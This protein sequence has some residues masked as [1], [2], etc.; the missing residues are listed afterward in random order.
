MAMDVMRLDDAEREWVRDHLDVADAER[1]QDPFDAFRLLRDEH[2]LARSDAHLDGFWV[3]SRHAD[4]RRIALDHRGFLSSQGMAIP[5]LGNE[6]PLIPIEI[7][8]P[9]HREYRLLIN[10]LF[11][12]QAVARSE[13]HVRAE[14]RALVRRILDAHDGRCDL[15]RALAYEQPMIVLWSEPFLGAPLP[16]DG[17]R[18]SALT[19]L[20]QQWV[21]DFKHDPSRTHAAAD[22]MR[23][24]LGD[25]LDDR[26]RRPADDIPTRLLDAR[27]D[28]R[29]LARDECVDFL[30]L[31]L[32]AG[33]ATTGDALSAS[34]LHLATTPDHVAAFCAPDTD[35]VVATEELLRM[36]GPAQSERRTAA[37]DAELHGRTI[38]AG[39][40]VML[41][42]GSANRDERVFDRADEVVLDRSP[43]PH[44]GFGAGVHRCIGISLARLQVRVTLDEW[45]RA[46]PTFSV[47]D[48]YAP[49]WSVGLDR[50]LR[51]LDVEW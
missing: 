11:T 10:D 8:P 35:Q 12:Q 25:V 28:D 37:A 18:G 16:V 3:V 51:V 31:L 9:A 44:L 19:G 40:P 34:L 4:V 47:V 38:R 15:V 26:A 48:G 14:T 20:F 41:L 22:T 39:D 46:V 45:L 13:P 33:T 23:A 49:R 6:R 17:R 24:Y 29:R 42:W 36:F 7:D 2:P 32:T 21:H 30:F 27:I 1:M 43:N 50:S 5:P